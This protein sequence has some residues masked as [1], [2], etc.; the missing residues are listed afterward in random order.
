MNWWR[1]VRMTVRLMI[2]MVMM[3]W[4]IKTFAMAFWGLISSPY[5]FKELGLYQINCESWFNGDVCSFFIAPVVY[6]LW[7]GRGSSGQYGNVT[8]PAVRDTAWHGAPGPPWH[9]HVVTWPRTLIELPPVWCAVKTIPPPLG[10]NVLKR[11]EVKIRG[12]KPVPSPP[13][14]LPSNPSG[15]RSRVGLC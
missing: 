9:G 3:I 1:L 6:N 12:A 2:T 13:W 5:L 14:L 4:N 15:S 8:C 11:S 7:E 10:G